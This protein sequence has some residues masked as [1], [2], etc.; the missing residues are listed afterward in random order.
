MYWGERTGYFVTMQGYRKAGFLLS[1][2]LST[3]ATNSGL[4]DVKSLYYCQMI[5]CRGQDYQK[6]SELEMVSSNFVAAFV[7]GWGVL[8]WGMIHVVLRGWCAGWKGEA[9][10]GFN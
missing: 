4:W 3:T 1:S 10:A 6:T 5:A 8:G 7:W 2:L 9:G